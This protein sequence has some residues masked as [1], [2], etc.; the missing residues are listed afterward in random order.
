MRVGKIYHHPLFPF[1]IGTLYLVL[2]GLV[3]YIADFLPK[4]EITNILKTWVPWNLK[5][6]FLFLLAGILICSTDIRASVKAFMNRRGILL[7]VILLIGFFTVVFVAPRT[8]RIF[9]DEHIYANIGQN[10][11]Y[12]NQTGSCD[13]GTFE[14]DEYSPRWL[15]YSKQ[16]SGWPFLIGIAFQLLGTDEVYPFFVNNLLFCGGLLLIFFITWYL[17]GSY[18]ASCLSALTFVLIPHNLIWSNTGAAE[19]SASFFVGLTVLCLIVHHRSRKNSHLFLVAVIVPLACQMRSES[20]VVVFWVLAGLLLLHPRSLIER[21][22][23]TIGLVTTALLLPHLL[24]LYA[25]MGHS[26]GAEG[27]KFSLQFFPRNLTTNGIYYLSNRQ[28]PV[29]FTVFSIIGLFSA[30]CSLRWR[31]LI[32]FWFLL[33]WG[34][35]LFFYAGGYGYGADVRYALVS[36]M[37]LAVL[38]GVG[39]GFIRDKILTITAGSRGQDQRWQCLASTLVVLVM[40]F[41]FLDFLPLVRQVGQEAW[42]ARYDH[43]YAREFITKIPQR[44][45]VLTH[46]PAMFLLWKRNAV[47]TYAGINNPDLMKHLMEKYQGH[48]YFHHGYWCNTRKERNRRLCQGIRQRYRLKEIIKAHEQDYSYGLYRISPR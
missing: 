31:F 18:F 5:I 38:A 35:F 21:R 2:V 40:V 25:V 39:A 11:A 34:V 14:Y 6:N 9:Y 23:W 44:S 46:T 8:H 7:A 29:L 4:G 37:P 33:F 24:H 15:Q 36:F 41:A 12:T 3:V 20:V 10:I 28:F 22:L 45:I 13:Y 19:P 27:A 47:Q 43:K 1:V 30:R 32:V 17:T 42:G 48:V 16:P 26:W